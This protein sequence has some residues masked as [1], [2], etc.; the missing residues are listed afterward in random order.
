MNKRAAIYVRVSSERQVRIKAKDGEEEEKASPAKQLSTCMDYCTRKG[1]TVVDT[2]RD[3]ERYRVGRR[4]VE[5]SGTR[6]DRPQLQRVLADA[7][8]ERFDVIVAWREDRLYRAFRPML[9]VIDCIERNNIDI[10]LT[11]DS[12]DRR[13]APVKAW[14]AKMELEAKHERLIIGISGRLESGRAWNGQEPY[15][16]QNDDGY[17]Q[18]DPETAKWVRAIWR[19]YADG[20]S[21]R[22][23]R[24]RLI[25]AGAPQS[26]RPGK[27]KWGLPR[28][29]K[30]LRYATYHTGI[31]PFVLEGNTFEVPCPP[32]IDPETA[33]R[34]KERRASHKRYPAGNIKYDYLGLGLVYCASCGW[35][36][37]VVTRTR[38]ST[39]EGEYRCPKALFGYSEPGC[40]RRIGWHK[41]DNLLWEKVNEFLSNETLFEKA[42]TNKI[43]ALQ[44]E[45]HLVQVDRA[46]LER[47]LDTL[48]VERQKIIT[49]WRKDKI[50]DNDYDLQISAL[51]VEQKEIERELAEKGLMLDNQAESLIE[52]AKT[53]RHEL[54]AGL[55]GLNTKPDTP[56]EI[57]RVFAIKRRAVETLVSRID[58]Q[59]DR[60]L[61]VTFSLDL[62]MKNLP[63]GW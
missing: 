26:R 13:F 58:V 60:S 7:D 4:L 28:L 40:P 21:V 45:K 11:N 23:I 57:K 62:Q 44:Q 5:P 6:T 50:T 17:L 12:F 38:H 55:V 8:A 37:H 15:G 54:R 22:E 1:Y 36:M 32:L 14:A 49:A 51:T 59:G 2:Y 9:D 31:Q 43:Q 61:R 30:I 19:W 10:E 18:I 3:I 41:L 16:Y 42:I 53:Y 33:Q 46:D 39:P 56:E 52:F 48:L 35:K 20:M 25:A 63:A 47:K 34:V 29:R 27:D 24:Q